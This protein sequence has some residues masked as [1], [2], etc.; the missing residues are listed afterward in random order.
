M[1]IESL[2]RYP[3]KG[4]TPEPVEAA[5]LTPGRCIPWDRAF[6]FAQG[7]ATLVPENPSW[8]SKTKFMCLMRNP[9]IALLRTKFDDATRLLTITAPQVGSFQSDPFSPSGQARLKEFFI[10]FL[11]PE[12]RYGPEGQAPAFRHFPNHSFCDHKSQVVSLIGLGS[13]ATLEAAAGAPRDKR[14]FRAN[15]YIENLSAWE[16]FNWIGKTLQIGNATLLVEDRIDRC[17]ATTVNPDSAIRDANPVKELQ[18]NFGHVDLGIYA[19]V[20]GH[21]TIRPGDEIKVL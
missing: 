13:L 20:L 8:N 5:D 2:Y 16:E 18:Q 14:R 21:G 19:K 6:A 3:V 4:L 7:D 9:S 11:G 15:I 12:L 17:S 10:Q 1:K